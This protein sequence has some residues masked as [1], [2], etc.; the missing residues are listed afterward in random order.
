MGLFFQSSSWR[1]PLQLIECWLPEPSLTGRSAALSLAQ[2][3]T[4]TPAVR[5][6]ARAGWLGRPAANESLARGRHDGRVAL[7]GRIDEVCRELDRLADREA[8][9]RRRLAR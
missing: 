8:Q 4:P 9:G 3:A 2:A 1:K 5:R 6:F 7:A